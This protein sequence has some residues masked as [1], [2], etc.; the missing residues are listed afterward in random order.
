V[1][2]KCLRAEEFTTN[3]R[4]NV[5]ILSEVLYYTDAHQILE[6]YEEYLEENG[7]FI[8]SVWIHPKTKELWEWINT[9][10]INIDSFELQNH[11][12]NN[13]WY[14]GTFKP[15]TKEMKKNKKLTLDSPIPRLSGVQQ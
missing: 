1:I 8:I 6:K 9:V 15:K 14:I 12:T 7:I 4:F 5:I 11:Q 10:Y 2:F 3:K 13:R